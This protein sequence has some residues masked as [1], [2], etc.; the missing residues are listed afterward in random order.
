M[1]LVLGGERAEQTYLLLVGPAPLRPT[2]ATVLPEGTSRSILGSQG[3]RVSR[4][5][6]VVDAVDAC[7]RGDHLD[8][9]DGCARDVFG[10]NISGFTTGRI[11]GASRCDS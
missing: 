1:L 6:V 2:I 11:G 8:R 10:A 7:G 9:P 3:T 5:A 4:V